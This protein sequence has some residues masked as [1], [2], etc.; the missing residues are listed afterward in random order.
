MG[1]QKHK[2]FKQ[3]AGHT[4]SHETDL[5]LLKLINTSQTVRFLLDGVYEVSERSHNISKQ[6]QGVVEACPTLKAR[7]LGRALAE[8]DGIRDGMQ[9][10]GPTSTTYAGIDV[11]NSLLISAKAGRP[12]TAKSVAIRDRESDIKALYE[13]YKIDHGIVVDNSMRPKI[14]YWK[15][16]SGKPALDSRTDGQHNFRVLVGGFIRLRSDST[17]FYRVESIMTLT[18]G[19]LRRAYLVVVQMRRNGAEEIDVAPFPVLTLAAT[20]RIIINV[21]EVDPVILHFITKSANSWWY[22]PFVPHFI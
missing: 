2:V 7:F 11:S 22:N 5:Q 10:S 4:N 18:I 12:V 1:E 13:L 6:V 21:K 14:H 8:E 3:H 20:E 16:L 17:V 19:F 15:Y 9:Q